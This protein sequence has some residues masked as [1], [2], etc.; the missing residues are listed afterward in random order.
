MDD[1]Q[2]KAILKETFNTV[3]GGYDNEALRFFPLSA[4]H[5]LPWPLPGCFPAAA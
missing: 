4:G 2:R 5:M 3:S 1:Q